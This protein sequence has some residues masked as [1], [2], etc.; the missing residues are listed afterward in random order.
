MTKSRSNEFESLQTLLENAR[1]TH[2]KAV[3]LLSPILEAKESI[4]APSPRADTPSSTTVED[5]Q[6]KNPSFQG[7]PTPAR[8]ALQSVA[9]RLQVAELKLAERN[10]KRTEPTTPPAKQ[11]VECAITPT[12]SDPPS[13]NAAT[14][15]VD[16][17]VTSEK[18]LSLQEYAQRFADVV[19]PDAEFV[20]WERYAAAAAAEI[21]EQ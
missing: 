3:E 12:E 20:S 19:H 15:E 1:D 9:Q 5:E 18:M 4:L 2:R 10:K 13:P 7:P 16:L 21:S 17:T 6:E 8:R 11:N 14:E